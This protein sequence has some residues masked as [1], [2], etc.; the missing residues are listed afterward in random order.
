MAK[1]T[2]VTVNTMFPD[3]CASQCPLSTVTVIKFLR[4]IIVT[5]QI[6]SKIIQL[7]ILS[8]VASYPRHM[9]SDSF[10]VVVVVMMMMVVVMA[11]SYTHLT[12]TTTIRV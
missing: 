9:L 6:W 10:S 2:D 4:G 12:L 5:D 7:V 3:M 11:V 8:S 1:V